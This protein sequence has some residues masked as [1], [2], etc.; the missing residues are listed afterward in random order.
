MKRFLIALVLLVVFFSLPVS[1]SA[2]SDEMLVPITHE[3]IGVAGWYGTGR[4]ECL[5]CRRDRMMAN[6]ERLDDQELMVACGTDLYNED[7]T[8]VAGSCRLFDVGTTVRITNLVNGK[9]VV[10]KVTDR[11][12]FTSFGR[13][14]DVTKAV[15]DALDME[16]LAM[17]KV[18]LL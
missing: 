14:L 13:I 9:S 5:G 11:G 15:R 18:E 10:A 12:G 17:I 16:D 4:G 8:I 6:G 1:V 7:G 3:I 2:F